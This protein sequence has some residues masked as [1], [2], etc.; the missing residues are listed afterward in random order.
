MPHFGTTIHDAQGVTLDEVILAV[1]CQPGKSKM[2][3]FL[4]VAFSRVE[5]ATNIRLYLALDCHSNDF[6]YMKKLRPNTSIAFCRAYTTEMKQHVIQ[7]D[8]IKCAYDDIRY[9]ILDLYF[10]GNSSCK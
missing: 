4:Y 10:N 3:N 1:A 7:K 6:I 5:T 2:H 8:R 9:V